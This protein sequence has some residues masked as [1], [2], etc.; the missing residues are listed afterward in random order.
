[1]FREFL[2]FE[3]RYQLRSPLP[4][5]IALL[6]S[7][8]AFLATVSDQVTIGDAIGNVNRNAPS[9]ILTILSVFSVLGLV[10]VLLLVAQPLLRDVDLRTE[11]LFFSA[12]LRKGDYLWGRATGGALATLGIFVVV[13]LVMWIAA[14]MPDLDPQ[15]VGA[16]H[17]HAV[18]VGARRRHRSQSDFQRCGAVPA[19]RRDAAAAVGVS[20]GLW[21]SSCCGRVAGTMLSD[22]RYD[23]IGS[24]L[25]PF[26]ARS[27]RP[28]HALLVCHRSATTLL[29]DISGLLL[30]NR[31]I[32]LSVPLPAML[33]AGACRCSARSAPNHASASERGPT[34]R[35]RHPSC[36]LWV[37][38]PGG[39]CTRIR[40][41]GH[42]AEVS[43]I[44]WLSTPQV[45]CGACRF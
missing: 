20:S 34:R 14:F 17:R 6:L 13:A 27:D 41:R 19:R 37:V 32:W 45:Y 4:W 39:Q 18:P 31:A 43:F 9:V 5:L 8:L 29:P 40:R 1:M 2:R 42:G 15:R 23:T 24:L 28:R 21:R 10:G 3:L 30:M 11:E 36:A 22:I 33:V 35:S 16:T 7:F 38:A 12:P 44:N 26:G 25:D